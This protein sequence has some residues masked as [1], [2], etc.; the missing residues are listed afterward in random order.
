LRGGYWGR[1]RE[2]KTH[3]CLAKG[4][5]PYKIGFS[6]TSLASANPVFREVFSDGRFAARRTLFQ[7]RGL[8]GERE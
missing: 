4:R 3:R 7:K 5:G 8:A 2:K 6:Q 1:Q